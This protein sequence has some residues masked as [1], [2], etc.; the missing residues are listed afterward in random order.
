MASSSSVSSVFYPVSSSFY[1]KFKQSDY[2]YT[3]VHEIAGTDEIPPSK[4][5]RL[6][7]F[8]RNS[9]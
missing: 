6:E 8:G 1:G 2:P 7:R 9:K 4:N 5:L 3:V